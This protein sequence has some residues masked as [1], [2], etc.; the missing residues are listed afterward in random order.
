[1]GISAPSGQAVVVTQNARR[2]AGAG[3]GCAGGFCASAIIGDAITMA[4]DS[5]P[6]RIVFMEVHLNIEVYVIREN[7][8]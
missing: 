7:V 8:F 1:M 5:T 6:C 2:G 4:A 3:A